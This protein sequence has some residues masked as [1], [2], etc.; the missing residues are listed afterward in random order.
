[1]VVY[2]IDPLIQARSRLP[3]P[4]LLLLP[5]P[6]VVVVVIVVVVVVVIVIVYLNSFQGLRFFVCGKKQ[7]SPSFASAADRTNKSVCLYLFAFAIFAFKTDFELRWGG[8]GRE[9]WLSSLRPSISSSEGKNMNGEEREKKKR[10]REIKRIE[11][12]D[13]NSNKHRKIRFQKI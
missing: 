6:V 4:L 5:Q 9:A 1:M 3:L 7:L 12:L 8:G 13:W 11:A 10:R 2:S